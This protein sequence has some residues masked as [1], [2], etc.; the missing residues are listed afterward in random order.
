MT[1]DDVGPKNPQ[2]EGHYPRFADNKWHYVPDELAQ[3]I[4]LG[5]AGDGEEGQDWVLTYTP[6]RRNEDDR[7]KILVRLTPRALHELYI[8]TKGA[9]QQTSGCTG[10][11][12]SA[13]LAATRSISTRRFR[14]NAGSHATD[15]VRPSTLAR[16]TGSATTCSERRETAGRRWRGTRFTGRE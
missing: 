15:A 13:T 2:P 16:Q 5:P 7:E 11:A 3:T 14:T 8:E 1:E 4:S 9:S 6:E 10:T 12:Q